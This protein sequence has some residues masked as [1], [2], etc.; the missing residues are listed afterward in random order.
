MP[1]L[2]NE[3]SQL[4]NILKD[5]QLFS[6]RYWAY[7]SSQYALLEIPS[8]ALPRFV[9]LLT[10]SDSQRTTLILLDNIVASV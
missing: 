7:G 10:P 8:D 6:Y 2:L 3:D 1:L 9:K 5:E 4:L